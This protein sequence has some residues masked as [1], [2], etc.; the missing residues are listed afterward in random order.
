MRTILEAG[1]KT[2][3]NGDRL[4]KAG[5]FAQEIAAIA[6]SRATSPASTPSEPAS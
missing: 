6:R 5:E 3:V 4:A 2:T 1:Y